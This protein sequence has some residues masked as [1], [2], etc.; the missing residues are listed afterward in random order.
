MNLLLNILKH[1]VA[2]NSSPL[3]EQPPASP[4][5]LY[6]NN[7]HERD[8]RTTY[9]SIAKRLF[10]MNSETGGE[11]E[12]SLLRE[13]GNDTSSSANNKNESAGCVT[14]ESPS[15][16]KQ[17]RFLSEWLSCVPKKPN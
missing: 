1:F 5:Q 3:L 4:S 15:L 16:S 11:E 14:R 13:E 6:Q 8:L 2:D 10:V 7:M 12:K 17:L 9:P